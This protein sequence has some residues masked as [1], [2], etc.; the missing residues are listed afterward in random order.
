MKKQH[1]KTKVEHHGAAV[2][3]ASVAKGDLEFISAKELAFLAAIISPEECRS[4]AAGSALRCALALFLESNAVVQSY[5]SATSTLDDLFAFA[6]DSLG[7]NRLFE[8]LSQRMGEQIDEPL[9]LSADAFSDSDEVRDFLSKHCN[10]EGKK[11]SKAWGKVRTVWDNFRKMHIWEANIHNERNKDRIIAAEKR[12]AELNAANTDKGSLPQR[13][14]SDNEVWQDGEV[15]FEEFKRIVTKYVPSVDLPPLSA[16]R[17]QA[18]I[19]HYEIRPLDI[20]ALI[21]WKRR[22]KS[23]GGIKAVRPRTREE[24]LGHIKKNNP[25][26]KK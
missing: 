2:S 11:G 4:G 25:K 26:N 13:Q 8:F 12:T 10:F 9:R 7:G 15:E 21:E 24:V 17:K 16:E 3:D 14:I 20:Q 18:K 5:N 19:S 22:I 23:K 1:G 6:G